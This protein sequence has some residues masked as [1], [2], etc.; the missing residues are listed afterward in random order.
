VGYV[1]NLNA[2]QKVKSFD[3]VVHHIY[4]VNFCKKEQTTETVR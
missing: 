1:F 2:Y 3:S 4:S